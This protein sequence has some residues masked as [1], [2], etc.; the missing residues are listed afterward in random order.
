MNYFNRIQPKTKVIPRS[1]REV[2]TSEISAKKSNSAFAV[3]GIILFIVVT[4]SV[5]LFVYSTHNNE[6]VNEIN[7]QI[8][9]TE[10][11]IVQLKSKINS[12]ESISS[13]EDQAKSLGL[14]KNKKIEVIAVAPENLTLRQGGEK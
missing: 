9:Q 2:R 5:L 3:S 11:E 14:I 12:S 4:F 6:K 1:F 7:A 13:L 8:K 10:S